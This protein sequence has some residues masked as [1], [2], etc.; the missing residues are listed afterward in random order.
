MQCT[1]FLEVVSP[2]FELNQF[3]YLPI[4]I[5]LFMFLFTELSS[6]SS[7]VH[8]EPD[9]IP[10]PSPS[11]PRM[12][13]DVPAENE[14]LFP[15]IRYYEDGSGPHRIEP[16][17]HTVGLREGFICG[18]VI[19]GRLWPVLDNQHRRIAES[20]AL[21]LPYLR[22]VIPDYETIPFGER[23]EEIREMAWRTA[24]ISEHDY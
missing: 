14:I 19:G 20:L 23:V 13:V 9:E 7:K 1:A 17:N 18:V 12:R 11:P 21:R 24:T 2:G 22:S 4:K 6:Q 8:P 10:T 16:G 5:R 15:Q 3:K